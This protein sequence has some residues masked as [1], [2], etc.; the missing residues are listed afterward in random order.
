[1][2]LQVQV[3]AQGEGARQREQGREDHELGSR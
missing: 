2:S 3:A 1:M